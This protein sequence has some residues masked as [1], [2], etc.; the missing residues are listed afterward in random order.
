[1][2]ATTMAPAALAANEISVGY[3]DIQVL[4]DVSISV[5]PG[6]IVALLGRNG[7]GKSTTLLALGGLLTPSAGTV[8][9]NG[10]VCVGPAHRRAR[11]GL[12][13]VLEERGVF[14]GL[15]VAQNLRLGPGS[16][17]G[18]LEYF[19][20]LETHLDRPAGL[21]SGG[22]Q[23]MLAVAR[24]LATEPKALMIDELSLGLAPL[25][26]TRIM[27]SLAQARSRGV[28]VL[29]VEQHARTA[30]RNADRAYVLDQGRVVIDGDAGDL[31]TRLPELEAA[32]LG[33]GG[34]STQRPAEDAE[35]TR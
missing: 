10:T 13:Y 24:A 14:A 9:L 15:T 5:Q 4:H 29:L 26:V 32:Y 7:A 12:A 3:G 11:R 22:Q 17:A 33:G 20:E 34:S 16:V 23:Q 2:T 8:M 21:L 1:M 19:P 25:V 18:A 28:G 31:L 35:P 30:L 27:T 6:E